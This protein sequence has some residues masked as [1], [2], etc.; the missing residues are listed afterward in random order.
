V[1][2][3]GCGHEDLMGGQRVSGTQLRRGMR[4]CGIALTSVT[5]GEAP[6]GARRLQAGY[7]AAAPAQPR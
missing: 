4:V 3:W 2:G 5:R 6:L 1:W 7:L